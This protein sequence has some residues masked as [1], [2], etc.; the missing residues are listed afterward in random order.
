MSIPRAYTTSSEL[1]HVIASLATSLI[2]RNNNLDNLR[3]LVSNILQI[4]PQSWGG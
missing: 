2:R 4:L 1:Y 3:L